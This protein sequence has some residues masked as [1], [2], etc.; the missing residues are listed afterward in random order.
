MTYKVYN[1][2]T[3]KSVEVWAKNK[4]E[5]IEKVLRTLSIGNTLGLEDNYIV[6][7]A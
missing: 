7:I 1:K 4:K 3:R 6:S 5:A 2:T